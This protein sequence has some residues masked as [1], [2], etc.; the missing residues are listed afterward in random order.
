MTN[1]KLKFFICLFLLFSAGSHLNYSFH[2]S[3]DVQK[4]R[5]LQSTASSVS[6]KLIGQVGGPT[7][8]VAVKD[9]YAYVGIGMRVVI[10]DVSNTSSIQQIGE[11]PVFDGFVTGV[12]LIED[13]AYI[14][15]GIA[16]FYTVDI[17][18][19]T[20]PSV[21]G[22]YDT[23]GYA[24]NIFVRGSCAYVADGWEGLAIIN[25][26]DVS[27]PHMVGSL[28]TIGY[29]FDVAVADNT[30]YIAAAGAGL[31]VVD[32][33][34]ASGP[35]EI[36]EYNTPG[37]AFGIAHS[38]GVVYIADG[39]EGLR[40]IDVYD[41]TQ[42]ILLGFLETPGLAFGVFVE[43]STVYIADAFKGLRVID[44]SSPGSPSEVGAF[45]FEEWG[46][47]GRM[48]IA[49]SK[50]Y[51]S[52]RYNGL[53]IVD[54]STAANPIQVGLYFPLGYAREVSVSGN[55]ACVAA[56]PYGLRL[57]DI[58][59]PSRPKEVGSYDTLNFANVVSQAGNYAYVATYPGEAEAGLHVVDI[60]NPQNPIRVGFHLYDYPSAPRDIAISGEMAYFANEFGLELI[61]ISNPFNPF[62]AGFIELMEPSSWVATVGV[63]ISGTMAYV[64]QDSEGIKIVDVTNQNN[65]I[66]I[67]TF[68][69][70][71]SF[72]ED[73]TVVGDK[74]YIAD[75]GKLFR[76][77]DVSNPASPNEL[78]RIP[79]YGQTGEVEVD[80]NVA[81][82]ANGNSG[83]LAI[84]VSD[85]SNLSLLGEFNTP[86]FS[87][88]LEK[89]SNLLYVAD[90]DAGL[91]IFEIQSTTNQKQTSLNPQSI[92]HFK[93]PGLS[94][95]DSIP[96]SMHRTL[97]K[98]G[99]DQSSHLTP[100]AVSKEYGIAITRVVTTTADSGEGSLRWCVENAQYGDTITFNT[101]VFPPENPATIL[102]SGQLPGLTQGNITI[103]ASNAGVILDGKYSGD[104]VGIMLNSNGNIIRGLQILNFSNGGVSIGA[105]E[106]NII[107]GDRTIGD[108]PVGQGNV[109]SGN[110]GDGISGGGNNNLI[111]GNLI[112]VDVSGTKIM[113][114]TMN[115][116][117]LKNSQNNIIG[118]NVPGER[119]I[120]CGNGSCGVALQAPG[121]KGNIIRG[122]YIGTDISGRYDLGNGVN[123]VGI[124]LGAFNN[125]IKS[126]LIS[127][128]H[129]AGILVS[130]WGSCYNTIVGNIIGL[131]AT[132]QNRLGN[133]W[134]GVFVGCYGASFNR[135][136]GT[137]PEDRNIISGNGAAGIHYA[138]GISMSGPSARDNFIIGNFLGTDINGTSASGQFAGI[139]MGGG[140]DHNFIGGT[141]DEERNVISGNVYG[142]QL[143][144]GDYNSI[145][146]NYIGISADGT[147]L[148]PAE[149][150]GILISEK[151]F[152]NAICDNLICGDPGINLNGD[153]NVLRGNTITQSIRG[154]LQELEEGNNNFIYY[155]K[156][157]QNQTQATDSGSNS[158]DRNGAGNYWSDYT[159]SDAD[160]D[161][162]G[163]TSYSIPDNGTDHYPLISDL[164]R[165][166]VQ[167]N[168]P[169]SG[170]VTITPNKSSHKFGE[171]VR[172]KAIPSSDKPFYFWSGGCPSGHENDNPLTVR[173]DSDRTITANF[174]QQY[175]LTIEA[176]SGGTTDPSP[177]TYTHDSGTSETIK[178]IPNTGYQFSNWSGDASGTANPITV[179][180]D[181]DKSIKANF[182]ATQTDGGGGGSCFIA[183][184]CY[185]TPMAEE[186]KVLCAFRDR[187]L[188]T[189][190]IGS[191]FVDFYYKYSRRLAD[192][193]RD[194][195]NLKAFIRECLKP[196]IWIASKVVGA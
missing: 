114:N 8:A 95:R 195:E 76:V 133:D 142:I 3:Y 52:D 107:G 47:A 29:A 170:S 128:N 169:G 138:A 191:A 182:T 37:Y 172:L 58:S 1:T 156:F 145:T 44:V 5:I 83:V 120:I 121:S 126:N 127:G 167:I 35:M 24:E 48:T 108:G 97:S 185:E 194:K 94:K 7:Q 102:L 164:N 31:K 91:L 77:L 17:S 55:Y 129:R 93:Y 166:T 183:T 144:W 189:N 13:T 92:S 74:A 57:I 137:S 160:G 132:G 41:S 173:M 179:T 171:N 50:V 67:G 153:D 98:P 9:N 134:A 123:G 177:G 190:P 112:G 49:G 32:V 151:T 64:A 16:G 130:D 86:G 88:K 96:G 81:Y 21:L 106:G 28:S 10:L 131:D 71:L 141:T 19:P 59:D 168:P 147:S 175:T 26:S 46:H 15:A 187:Y 119:N 109:I 113:G 181:S 116:I 2:Y 111:I 42:P 27:N 161:G 54:V 103:D 80:G 184:A 14:T 85:P 4:S 30:A 139:G 84:D 154:F 53:R 12:V 148:L 63:D 176:G 39:W 192:F 117:F 45:E 82:V 125:L 178:A 90:A 186:V 78:G 6:F 23:P 157:L 73:I 163:D 118:G 158:W 165:L 152:H 150:S 180:M 162:I 40:I 99:R 68:A 155:N 89:E 11:T 38:D 43:G 140:A 34:Y 72:S 61:D 62:I 36:G 65:L 135:I 87:N 122:N 149:H 20:Q 115:G 75:G 100:K 104:A 33:E 196:L 101:S 105:G 18:S 70:E 66:L 188:L 56:G 193:I 143:E 110:G 124:E 22:S 136:G 159:G 146:G 174:I 60:S 79:T 69:D 25:I 51:V